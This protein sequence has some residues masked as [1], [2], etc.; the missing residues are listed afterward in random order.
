MLSVKDEALITI[1]IDCE[2]EREITGIAKCESFCLL[3]KKPV[4]ICNP[5]IYKIKS[6]C[7]CIDRAG[8]EKI[9][10]D[11]VPQSLHKTQMTFV[12]RNKIPPEQK[13]QYSL[14]ACC[15]ILELV[16]TKNPHLLCSSNEYQLLTKRERQVL[17][18]SADGFTANEITDMLYISRHTV[19]AHIEACIK[20]LQCRNKPHAIARA[21]MLELL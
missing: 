8:Y 11:F 19:N 17:R 21:A 12:Y 18:L 13:V 6:S 10:Y 14:A 15:R 3:I 5:S 16:K 4:T 1:T 9:T 2:M 7:F 20:K